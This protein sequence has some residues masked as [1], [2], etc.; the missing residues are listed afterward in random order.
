LNTVKNQLL[1]KLL[2]LKIIKITKHGDALSKNTTSNAFL[3]K[4]KIEIHLHRKNC[5]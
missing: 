5:E 1:I 2:K 3:M 4:K